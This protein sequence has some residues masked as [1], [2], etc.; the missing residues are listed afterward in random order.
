MESSR[1]LVR[2]VAAASRPGGSPMDA[3]VGGA[4]VAPDAVKAAADAAKSAPTSFAPSSSLSSSPAPADGTPGRVS[5]RSGSPPEAAGQA[6]S[7]PTASTPSAAELEQAAAESRVLQV[8][9]VEPWSSYHPSQWTSVI[10]PRRDSY[11]AASS[12][13]VDGPWRRS[14]ARL[15][16]ELEHR[17]LGRYMHQQEHGEACQ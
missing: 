16:H 2:R 6:K 9:S 10:M 12:V 11:T 5:G 4:P 7:Q 8:R 17:H 14:H 13:H 1:L 3:Q 15:N